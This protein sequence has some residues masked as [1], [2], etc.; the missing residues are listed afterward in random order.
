MS[1]CITEFAARSMPTGETAGF[2]Q[3]ITM[4]GPLPSISK[5]T[6]GGI[7]HPITNGRNTE[8]FQFDSMDDALEAFARGEFLVVMDDENEGDLIVAA[9]HRTTEKMA[10]MIKHTRYV[11]IFSATSNVL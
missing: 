8:E 5:L 10:W 6:N 3:R 4:S 11:L 1:G 7:P 2:K 9:S